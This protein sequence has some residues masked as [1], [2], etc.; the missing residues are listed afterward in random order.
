MIYTYL[1]KV[2]TTCMIIFIFTCKKSLTFHYT[3][4]LI[5]IYYGTLLCMVYS[6]KQPDVFHYSPTQI[7]KLPLS[8]CMFMNLSTQ[9]KLFLLGATDVLMLAKNSRSFS[10]WATKTKRIETLQG[11]G[12]Y[13][14]CRRGSPWH[15]NLGKSSPS[16]WTQCCDRPPRLRTTSALT[17]SFVVWSGSSHV[18]CRLP[19]SSRRFYYPLR[20]PP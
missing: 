4:C 5:M 13:S 20:P 7:H 3:G 9:K 19:P 2:F 14:C 17:C 15:P 12:R 11:G 18:H 16:S 8:S 1:V 6:P 10:T